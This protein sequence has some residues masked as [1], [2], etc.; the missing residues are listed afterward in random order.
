MHINV[1][2]YACAYICMLH[3]I[4][5][6][7]VHAYICTRMCMPIACSA[8]A[9]CLSTAHRFPMIEGGGANVSAGEGEGEGHAVYS[10]IPA[11]PP[12]EG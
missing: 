1:H 12:G 7:Y 11:P 4:V 3:V 9:V 10:S 8:H 5:H 6:G 2:A